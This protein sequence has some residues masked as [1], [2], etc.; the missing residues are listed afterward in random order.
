V[1]PDGV[2]VD[3]FGFDAPL[4]VLG[5]EVDAERAPDLVDGDV[6][7]ILRADV[8][9]AVAALDRAS[10]RTHLYLD[11]LGR[12]DEVEVGEVAGVTQHRVLLAWLARQRL[13]TV[14]DLVPTPRTELAGRPLGHTFPST[15]DVVKPREA[16]LHARQDSP[17]RYA[18]A[19]LSR[20][21]R[22]SR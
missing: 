12:V 22:K 20:T 7:V 2:L 19:S 1:H 10:P 16:G 9:P 13:G 3:L 21:C 18:S 14:G 4:D 5:G 11:A 15:A 6:G 8:D 17:L